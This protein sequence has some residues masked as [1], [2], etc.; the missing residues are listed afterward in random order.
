MGGGRRMRAPRIDP[1][2]SAHY[3]GDCRELLRRLPDGCVQTCI[4][5]PP[6][7]NLR[8]YG[9]AGQI[10]LEPT[11]DAYIDA[12]VDVFEEVRRVLR[13]DGTLWLNLGDSYSHG[14][15]GTRDA[16]RW[17]I[18]ARNDHMP[19]K[20]ARTFRPKHAKKTTGLKP[21]DLIGIPW[22]V[23][24]ALQAAGWW[25]RADIIWEK[26]NAMPES[27]TDR[28]TKVH[29]YIFLLAKSE[30][31]YYNADAISEESDNAGRTIQLGDKSFAKRQADGIGRAPVGNGNATEY[32]VP[33]RRNK[34]SVW[35]VSTT[36]YA[37]AHFATFPEAL[38]EPCVLAAS[39][40][41]DL[42]LD[43]FF[44]SGT[45][46][47]VAERHERRWIGFDLNPAYE[48]LQKARTSQ[49]SLALHTPTPEV[50]IP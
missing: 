48:A 26:P 41:G 15:C 3:T 45:T 20:K 18:Q 9:I 36:P 33:A 5:S 31:Y 24:F 27:V 14:G 22:R 16:A 34:R 7:Y 19:D 21:K 8:D 42:V 37:D 49:R 25:L 40:P 44:G 38:I 6:Y 39:R 30:A 29:E 2:V 13:P 35:K 12:L 4:T 1:A 10:G 17:P 46:G 32:V 28:P 11:P 47:E 43:P 50:T 23:A